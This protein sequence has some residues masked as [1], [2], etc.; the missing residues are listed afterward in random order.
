MRRLIK[1]ALLILIVYVGVQYI[2]HKFGTET[3]PNAI[4]YAKAE[5]NEQEAANFIEKFIEQSKQIFQDTQDILPD[6]DTGAETEQTK[7]A[8]KPELETPAHQTFSIY[9]IQMGD[10]EEAVEQELGK[11]QR[12]SMNEYGISWNTYHENY[13]NFV[14][15]GFDSNKKVAALYTNQDLIS[16]TNGVKKGS[17]KDSVLKTLG[18]P[19]DELTKGFVRYKFPEDRDYEV[20]EMDGSYVTVFFDKHENNTVTAMQIVTTELEEDR[21]DF[22]TDGSAQLEEGFE[23]QLFD[24]TNAS[25]VNNGLGVLTWEDNVKVTARKHSED[26]AKNDY[27]DHTNLD[28]ESPFDRMLS[29]G[30]KYTMAGENLAYGQYSSI[31]A[32]EGLMNSLGHRENILQEGFTYLGVGVAFNEKSQPY[33]TENFI[34]K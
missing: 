19:L 1:L 21:S 24:L 13:Q 12:T 3:I 6:W 10:S 30:I 23:F 27:F 33:Y 8:E 11:P 25:R 31:F 2:Q 29:D 15:V 9:N 18:N 20:F 32:H 16:S 7:Q 14:M 17:S 22:Y 34:T 28:G 26:M 5:V 4:D